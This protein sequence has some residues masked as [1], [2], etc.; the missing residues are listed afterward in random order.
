MIVSLTINKSC[1]MLEFNEHVRL[2]QSTASKILKKRSA[3][4]L[5]KQD[6]LHRKISF[7]K[8]DQKEKNE[9]KVCFPAQGPTAVLYPPDGPI[10]TKRNLMSKHVFLPYEDVKGPYKV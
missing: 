10:P 1:A 9:K 2:T 4:F 5:V 8:K 3:K 6:L 7:E